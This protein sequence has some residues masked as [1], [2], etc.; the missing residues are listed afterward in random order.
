MR[1]AWVKLFCE[2]WLRGSIRQESLEVR[3]I[4]T[5]L[6]AM[7]GDAAYGD[8][9]IASNGIIQLAE[10]VGFTDESIS[11]ILNVPLETWLRVKDR[12]SNHPDPGENRIEVVP[13]S[14]G[15]SIKIL[16]WET[17]QSEYRRQKKYR[18]AKKEERS[19]TPPKEEK[20]NKEREGE[21][22]GEEIVTS[23]T[24]NVTGNV[25]KDT[26]SII[27]HW[28]SKGIKA[29]EERETEVKEK[30]IFKIK[31]WIKDYS[32]DEILEA[33]NNYSEVLKKEDYFFSYSWQLWEFLDRG[34]VNF[35]SKNKPFENFS[36]DSR[37]YSP[38]QVGKN[39]KPIT[40]KEEQYQK[41]RKAKMAELQKQYENDTEEAMKKGDRDKLDEIENKIKD[42][43]AAF[44]RNYWDKG[45]GKERAV[46]EERFR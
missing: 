25:T 26:I 43:M 28:N 36:K 21:G 37:E 24:R 44:S 10:N 33:I 45:E 35:L 29:L 11:A 4:F 42:E 38:S 13:L 12:L 46:G 40:G 22:E 18:Q 6:L 8:P 20:K 31:K 15:F 34:L 5:D 2:R 9:D 16:N 14:Q 30:T 7:A 41:A 17:Y 19:P 32:L 39:A 1:R 23:V 27:D 3:A